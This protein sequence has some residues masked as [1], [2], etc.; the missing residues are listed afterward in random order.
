[1]K[2]RDTGLLK[3]VKFLVKQITCHLPVVSAA[4]I[5]ARHHLDAL[6]IISPDQLQIK[7]VKLLGGSFTAI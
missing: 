3:L 2:R 7:V 4:F 1:M 6:R 5:C